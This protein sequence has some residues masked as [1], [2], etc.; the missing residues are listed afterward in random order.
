MNTLTPK[1]VELYNFIRKNGWTDFRS[2]QKKLK[3]KN[4]FTLFKRTQSL[5]EKGFLTKKVDRC[6]TCGASKVRY[7]IVQ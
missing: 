5:V 2:M 1:Q 3:I 6:K 7:F 4:T